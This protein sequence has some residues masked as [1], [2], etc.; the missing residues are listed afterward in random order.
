MRCDRSAAALQMGER[1]AKRGEKREL[2]ENC[3]S[4]I[5]ATLDAEWVCPDLSPGAGGG[6]TTRC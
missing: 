3:L 5:R 6:G 2:V 4:A 1:A